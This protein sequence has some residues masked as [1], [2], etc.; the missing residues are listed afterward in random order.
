MNIFKEFFTDPLKH[1]QKAKQA[2]P[3]MESAQPRSDTLS[4]SLKSNFGDEELS[5]EFV[6]RVLEAGR[7]T[8]RHVAEG[9]RITSDGQVAFPI[10][11]DVSS[12]ISLAILGTALAILKGNSPMM[13]ADRAKQIETYCKRSLQRD[14]GLPADFA[15]KINDTLDEYQ[16]VFDTAMAD[17]KNPFGETFGTM[18]VRCLG[19]RVNALCIPGT[20][21]LNPVA[22]GT[23][24]DL[25]TITVRQ[26]LTFWK[27]N[28]S[29]P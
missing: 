28:Q 7:E 18:L 15:N 10:N 20:L 1:A 21:A 25:A 29:S 5:R 9:V 22:H 19:S 23:V 14:Y 6:R 13:A 16:A 17:K 4:G 27:D 11:N 8:C 2:R 26:V 12:E 3:A 24:A